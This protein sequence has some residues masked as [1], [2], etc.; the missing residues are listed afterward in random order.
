MEVSASETCQTD[1]RDVA[2]HLGQWRKIQDATSNV[3]CG[4]LVNL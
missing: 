3:A 2:K 4:G 1:R